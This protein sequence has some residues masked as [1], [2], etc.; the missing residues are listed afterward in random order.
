MKVDTYN[1]EVTRNS[2]YSYTQ[3]WSSR[4]PYK[5][6]SWVHL[7]EP[8]NPFSFDEALL[9]CQYSEDEWIAWIPDHG[10]TILHASQ[11]CLA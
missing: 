7:L 1:S 11:F 6:S 2:P 10:E 8:L 4:Q 5:A 3:T 9:L